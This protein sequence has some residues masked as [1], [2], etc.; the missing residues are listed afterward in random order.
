MKILAL[1]GSP[2]RGGNTDLLVDQVLR[3][4]SSRGDGTEKLRLYDI[5]IEA[6]LD[7][8]RCKK[9]DYECAL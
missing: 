3:G 6:C 5:E 4:C 8:R 7:C 2:R 9:G 1:I